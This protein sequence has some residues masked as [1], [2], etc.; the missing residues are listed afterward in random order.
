MF[1][2]VSN[3]L[4]TNKNAAFALTRRAIEATGIAHCILKKPSLKDT[5]LSAYP[6]ILQEGHAKQWKPS[7]QYGNAFSTKK[8]FPHDEPILRRLH[9]IYE[10][11]C[12]SD[13]H[14]SPFY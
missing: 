13:V 10:I 8:L 4:R 3:L 5:F 14:V 2:A 11:T 7:N 9:T 12:V 1:S 6:N